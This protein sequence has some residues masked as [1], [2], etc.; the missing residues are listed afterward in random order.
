MLLSEPVARLINELMKMPGIGP[1]SAQRLAYYIIKTKIEDVERLIRAL[2]DVK[3]KIRQ[4][5]ICFNLTDSDICEYCRSLD[6]SDELICVVA[7]A[8]DIPPIEKAGSF[9]GKYHVLGGL[10]SPL[11]GIGPDQLTI[12]KLLERINQ[13]TIKEIIVATDSDTSG[14]VT[15]LY[16][17]KILKPLGITVTRLA[18][19]LPMGASLEY[20]DEV[21][22]SR[23]FEG[24]REIE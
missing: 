7:S 1:K 6:R 4:C 13:D 3:E 24:R 23:A 19:G 16:I 17:G 11:D 20:A 2:V 5:K 8:K 18:Y 14:E 21:T 15:A 22:L 12:K 10:I 9:R